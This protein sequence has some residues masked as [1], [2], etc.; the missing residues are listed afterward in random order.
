[1]TVSPNTQPQP[2]QIIERESAMF[3]PFWLDEAL[4]QEEMIEPVPLTADV[5]T[6]VCI[7]GGGYTGLWT[8]IELKSRQPNLDVV[9]LEMKVC[10][11][12]ASGCNGGCVLTLAPRF[13]SLCK[14]YGLQEAKR[15]VVA[16]E[17]AVE[18]IRRFTETNGIA[19]DFRVDG[20][21]YIATNEAQVGAMNAVVQALEAEGINSW[22]KQAADEAIATS[23]TALLRESFASPKAGSL[24][25]AL[26]VRGLARVAREKGVRIYEETPMTGL[27]DDRNVPRVVTPRAN[28]TSKK[29]VL[30]INAWMASTFQQFS[31]S[32]LVVSSD[33]AITEPIPELLDNL[34]LNHGASI[35]DMRTFVHYYHTTSDGRLLFGKGGN[36]FAF[37]SKMIREFFEP[38]KYEGQLKQGVQRFFPTLVS[39]R[40]EQAWNGGSDRSTT[41]FP[42]FGNL[43]GHPNIHYGFGY[44]GNGVTLC[45]IGGKILASLC[46]NRDDEW[47]RCGFVGGPR[48]QFPPEPFRWIGSLVVR[49]AIRRKESA[50]DESRRPR[51]YDS[52]LA[53]LAR[54][55]GKVD[56]QTHLP[57]E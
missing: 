48:G 45:R 49:N 54:P 14:Y 57:T 37:G 44:S 4:K 52:Y 24:Q 47:S 8:A 1:M 25:P 29:V 10:G 26:L 21:Q 18:E 11:F 16:S 15:L 36:T 46:L 38:S 34:S 12:G 3:R 6:D 50:E 32:I 33:M 31:R 7:V 17:S 41:G 5:D 40:F 19:C 42:F 2:F 51:L 13:L 39:T 56:R 43:N 55:V 22:R 53:Q 30:A 35:C 28:V 9:V 20:A 23:G 27:I